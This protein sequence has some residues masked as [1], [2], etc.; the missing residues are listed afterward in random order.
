MRLLGSAI[1]RKFVFHFIL[2]I[3]L[4]ALT[5]VLAAS[6]PIALKYLVDGLK[7][8]QSSVSAVA[9]AGLWVGGLWLARVLESVRTLVVTTSEQRISKRLSEKAFLH[10]IR[11]PMRFHLNRRTGALTETINRGV[12][13]FQG[14]YEQAFVSFLPLILELGT[15]CL[16]LRTLDQPMFV[17]YFLISL[18]LYASAF[19]ATTR[20]QIRTNRASNIAFIEANA[21]LTDSMMNCETIKYFSAESLVKERYGAALERRVTAWLQYFRSHT[22]N[23]VILA[24]IFGAFVATTILFAARQVQLGA[25]SVGDFVLVQ[26]YALQLVRP[27]ESAGTTFQA[28]LNNFVSVNQLLAILSQAPEP[29]LAHPSRQAATP[30]E[31]EFR[32]VAFSY[33]Q[34]RPT[35]RDVSFRVPPGTTAGIVGASGAGK[36]SLVRLLVRMFEPESGQ[37]LL[38][39]VPLPEI[40]LT[41]LRQSVAV[42]PQDTTLFDESIAFNIGVGSPGSSDQQI[43]QATKIARLNGLISHLPQ[44]LGTVVGERG[45][46][47]SGGERQRVALARAAIRHPM[48]YVFDEATSSLDSRTER[49]IMANLREIAGRSTTLLIAHRLSTVV[50]ADQILVLDEGTIVE[51]GTHKELLALN[52]RYSALWHA[53]SEIASVPAA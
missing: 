53:Q 26:A 5:A 36:S 48:I 33:T 21:A 34:G 18:V 29:L 16:I 2:S 17:Y 39:G 30:C 20:W 51:S 32:K 38:N 22:V 7:Q 46:K 11:L 13:G 44:G 40:P 15:M 4:T 42:V 24:T 43:E 14:I 12:L 52:G 45:L 49:D 50:H 47:L 1:D 37:I 8:D 25:M 10:I 31:L 27:I 41:Q 28:V 23:Q 35:L 6:T 3:L 19:A 9:L